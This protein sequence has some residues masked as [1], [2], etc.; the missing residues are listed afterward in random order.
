MKAASIKEIK[1]E[2]KNCSE[3]ELHALCLRLANFKK[4]NKELL[5]Y[6][7]YEAGDE[8]AYIESIKREIDQ[9]FLMMNRSNAYWIKK[10]LRKVQRSIRKFVRYSKKKE[11]EAELFLYFCSKMNKMEPKVESNTMLFNIYNKQLQALQKT[12][13]G[14]HEDVQYDHNSEIDQFRKVS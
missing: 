6:L 11:T 8:H 13:K 14:L 10:S 9:Q 1:A 3:V 4:E 7:L 5:T 12:I 2:L